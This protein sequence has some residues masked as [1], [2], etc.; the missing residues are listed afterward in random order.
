[1]A[2]LQLLVLFVALRVQQ[3]QADRLDNRKSLHLL[4]ILPF[5]DSRPNTGWDRA[6]ELIPA[7]QLAVD[8]INNASHILPGYKLNLVNVDAE[9]CGVSLVTK[10]LINTYSKLFTPNISLNVVGFTGLFCSTVTDAITLIFGVPNMTYLQL[11]GSTSPRHRDSSK[12][13]WLVHF[14]SSADTINDAM[15]A[16]IQEFSWT[17]VSVIFENMN[18]FNEANAENLKR[19]AR[20]T[21]EFNVTASIPITGPKTDSTMVLMEVNSRIVYISALNADTAKL[22][23]EAYKR[24]ALFP[25]YVYFLPEKSLPGLLSKVHTTDCTPKQLTESLEGAFFLSYRLSNAEATKLVSNLTYQEYQQHYRQRV[26]EMELAT[27]TSLSKEN[28]YA[29]AMHD[30]IWAFALALGKAL[31]DLHVAKI[32]LEDLELHQTRQFASIVRSKFDNISFQGVSGFVKFNSDREESSLVE[33]VQVINGSSE[34]VGMYDPDA[35]EKLQLLRELSLPPDTFEIRTLLLPLW[36]STFFNIY[37]M[38]WVSVTTFVVIFLYVMKHRPEV[39]ASSPALS[40][41]MIFGCYLLFASTLIR[42]ITKGYSVNNRHIF[43]LFCN[44]QTWLGMVGLTLIFSALLLRLLRISRIFKAYGK[45]SPYWKNRY[46]ILCILAISFGEIIILIVWT[47]VGEIEVVTTTT[48]QSYAVPHF[49]ERRSVCSTL[50]VG[51]TVSLVYNGILMLI[52]V[53]LAVRTRKIRLSNFKD[54]K[55]VNA[56]IALTCMTLGLLIPLWYVID[57]VFMYNILGHFIV[58]FALSCT[59]VYCQLFVFLPRVFT[60]VLHMVAERSRKGG[61]RTLRRESQFSLSFNL[62]RT[63]TAISVA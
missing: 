55:Q 47:V 56:F 7:A 30:E 61:Q 36:V 59:G 2:L 3:V 63:N 42:N 14:I 21:L 40:L 9:A 52:A 45:V 22:M 35:H 6:Y 54:T 58:C 32:N 48:Y 11:A 17:T 24:N 26:M 43:T 51:L 16:M 49:F 19:R 53:F 20:D 10:G 62:T 44:I 4:N 15:L 18:I 25:E 46:M 29:N 33:I 1:M 28:I 60:T 13:P 31:G 50:G 34:L 27:N 41:A 39:K 57:G 5:P 12:Y 23:C 38:F 37:F 8:Q